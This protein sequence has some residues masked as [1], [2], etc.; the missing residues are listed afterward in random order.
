MKIEE[1]N[2]GYLW[3]MVNSGDGAWHNSRSSSQVGG[4]GGGG[5]GKKHE[6]NAAAFSGLLFYD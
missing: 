1:F 5:G 6:I 2:R 4:G 3:M